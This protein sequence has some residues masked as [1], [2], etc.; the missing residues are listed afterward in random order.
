MTA[1]EMAAIHAEAMAFPA[2]WGVP[3]FEGFLAFPGAILAAEDAGF[4]L[5]RIIA[6]E[7]EL[8][9]V[10]V[11]PAARRRGIAARC[12]DAFERDAAA[13]G[14]TRAFLEVAATNVPARAL[15]VG[16]GFAEDGRRRG[17][18]D[19]PGGGHA[20][21]ILMSKALRTA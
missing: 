5:G 4:A 11:R 1:E 21:A 15:Y 20:D 8:L 7:A 10:A 18:Y 12:L 17:Y 14:A 19:L 16:A 3:T 2:P 13:R 9:T 6:D